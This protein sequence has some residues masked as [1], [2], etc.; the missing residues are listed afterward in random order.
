MTDV[1]KDLVSDARSAFSMGGEQLKTSCKKREMK[2]EFR[3]LNDI[4]AKTVTVKVGSFDVVTHERFLMMSAIHGGVKGAPDLDLGDSKEFPPLKI[5]TTKTVGTYVAKNKN[6]TIEEV[7]DEPVVKKVAPKRRPAPAVGE[8]DLEE[9]VVVETTETT[10]VETE[11]RIDVRSIINYDEE[12]PLVE[13]ES[14]KEKEIEPVATEGMSFEKITDS[15]DTEPLSKVLV[16]TKKSKSDEESMPIDDL[17]EQIP[18]NMMLPSVTATE[19]TRI[20]FGLGI[21]IPGVNDGDWYKASLP[22][23]AITDKGKA[24]LVEKDEIKG[25]LAREIFTLICTDIEF[26]VQ[27]R[28]Q[29]IEEIVSFFSSFSLCRL[30]FLGPLLDIA[31]KEEQILA[32]AE[33]DSLQTAVSRRLYII[34]K[35]RELLLPKFLEARNKNFESGTPTTAID[36]QVLDMLSDAHRVALE[37][38]LEQM[39]KYKLEWT[40]PINSRLFE[41]AHRYRGVVISRSNTNIRSICWIRFLVLIDGSWTAIEGPDMWVRQRRAPTYHK[42]E[43]LSKRTYMDTL[44]PIC[45]FFEPVQVVRSLPIVKTWAWARVCTDIIQFHHFGHLEPVGTCNFCIDIVPVGLLVDKSGVPKRAVNNVQYDIRIVDSLSVLSPD[46]VAEEP[47]Y[48]SLQI[49]S[50]I[51]MWFQIL[52]QSLH[53]F[54][55]QWIRFLLSMCKP[56]F[57]LRSSRRAFYEDLNVGVFSLI[58]LLATRAWLQPEL[59][60]RRLFTVGGGITD[61]ACKN[62]LVVVSVQYGPFNPYIPIRSTT[63]GKSRV[64]KDPIAM[65]TSW[66]SNSD[67]VSVTRASMSFQVVRTNQYNK[68]LGLIHS[69]NGNHL[70]SPNEGSSIDHQVTIHL[71][72]QNITMFPTNETWYFASQILVLISGGLIL[73]LTAQSTRN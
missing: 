59:Q 31:A 36:Q 57:T 26:L 60:E 28:D 3:L 61:S 67:I 53:S 21:E 6:I 51:Q 1:P 11:S 42:L 40:R 73:I 13:K 62:Q 20:K 64:A 30:E 47:V 23:I 37:E 70:E 17:L 66:R 12:D 71:H 32:W 35:Y 55:L 4:L 69:T 5:L 45:L 54:E 38:L 49:L 68:D 65:H 8:P 9:P 48:I 58:T 19:P 2:Y 16:R 24:P 7:A 10:T 63:I 52:Q 22:Y 27:S 14:E 50:T 34:A 41:G 39:R 18:E 56:E 44:D 15:E 25:H 46:P 72:A 33:T 43:L 29:V